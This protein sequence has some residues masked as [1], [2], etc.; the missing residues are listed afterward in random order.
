MAE[1]NNSNWRQRA[2]AQ[3]VTDKRRIEDAL[4]TTGFR[5]GIA[6]ILVLI[7]GGAIIGTFL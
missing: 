4:N 5:V 1:D 6:V 7:V 3:Q 2:A